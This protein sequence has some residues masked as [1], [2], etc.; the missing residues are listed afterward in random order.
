[1]MRNESAFKMDKKM[2]VISS[3]TGPSERTPHPGPNRFEFRRWWVAL[4]WGCLAVP[5]MAIDFGPEGMFSLTGFGKVEVQR[6]SN[7]CT[8]CQL[9]P[10]ENKQRLWA[11]DLVP[12]RPYG[13][14]NTHVTLFQPWLGAKYDLGGGFKANALLS[15]R[16]RDGA[17]DIPGFWYEKNVAISHDDYGSLRMGAMTTRTWSIADYPYGT[18]LGVADVWGS[19]G[20]GYGL[21]TNAVRYTSRIFD[22]AQG[23]LVLEASYD[24]GN[25]N[26]RVHKPQFLEL[27]AQF[28]KGDLVLDAMYQDS[29]NGNPQAWSHGPFTSLT[30]NVADDTKVG[31]SGQSIAMVMGRYQVNSQIEVS[32]GLR[33][34]RWSGAYAVITQPGVSAQWNN[35]FN[36]DWNGQLNGVANPGY[37]ATSTDWMIGARYKT[38][39]WTASTGMVHLGKAST[40]NP[41]ERGQSNSANVNTVGLN[42]N[43][44]NG[45]QVYGF[46]GMVTYDR[47]G[48]APMSM[49][50]NAA[51]T[52]VDSRVTRSGNWAG[53]GAVYV[54]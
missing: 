5:A 29:R 34:N 14:S 54:F 19:S 20:A 15:Q 25:R 37:A 42:Y 3:R 23:D 44:N 48:L 13:T 26:F 39:P 9:Y 28:H 53:L 32:G 52:N 16:W 1:M 47:L 21:L 12:G 49:P 11:D 6:G 33:G 18:N 7:H 4:G 45:F 8:D 46:V 30:P 27:Y 10:T 2:N 43:Y 40:A 51:F 17:E 41:S 35:M 31:G 36:V 38:G 50:G 22:V 24:Q